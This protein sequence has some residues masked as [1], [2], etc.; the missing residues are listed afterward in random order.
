MLSG[1]S[2]RGDE[3]TSDHHEWGQYVIIACSLNL[4]A[5]HATGKDCRAQAAEAR[6]TRKEVWSPR[7]VLTMLPGEQGN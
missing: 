7:D 4:E 1:R 5:G 3:L 6:Q 2:A